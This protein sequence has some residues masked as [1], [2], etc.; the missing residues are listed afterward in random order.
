MV[1]M[2]L[3]GPLAVMRETE[4]DLLSDVAHT[5][6][7]MGDHT[8]EDRKRLMDVA[9]DLR[10]LF[11]LVVIIGEFNAGK[12]SFVNALL[13]DALL[14]TGITPT[15]EMIELVRYAEQPNRKPIMRDESLREWAHPNTGAPGVAIVDTPGTGSVFQRHE[16]VAK[17]FLHRSDL[18]IFL[19]SA[20]RA[21]AETERIYL[22]M[23]KNYG[24]KII[25]IVNQVDLLDANEQVTVR[26]FIEQQVREL[27]NLQPLIFMV[28]AKQALA[29]QA[30]GS[31]APNA[32]GMDAVRAHLRGLFEE[33]PPTKQKLLAQL[34][35]AASVVR[36]Y[37]DLIKSKADAV[38]LDTT[39]VKE[40]QQELQKQSLGL[41]AQ[42]IEARA[43]IDKVFTGMRQRGMQFID[44]NLSIRKIGSSIN[45]DKLQAEFQDVVIG[46]ALR[47][48]NEATNGYINAVIDS[49][50]V[51]WR[52]VIDRLNQLREILEQELSGLD[53]GMYAEQRENLQDAIRIAE[54]EL[55]SY[56]TGRVV[57][58]IHQEFEDNRASFNVSA[59][60]ASLG[61]ITAIVAAGPGAAPF[62]GVVFFPAALV[63]LGGGAFA[64]RYYQRVQSETKKDFSARV[65]RLMQSYHEAL[66]E[67]T[68][69]E[70]ARLSQY[71]TQVLTPIFSRLEVLAQR[72]TV[73]QSQFEGYQR[74][75]ETLRKGIEES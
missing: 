39:R 14:P 64:L 70:R 75:V 5:L 55:K 25:L 59:I 53:A 63:A 23:A 24:K 30:S 68:R 49:S 54:A 33:T 35:M 52:G 34:D 61:V 67:L 60:A 9:Q 17:E 74:R 36:R 4:I 42:L 12:S 11:F 1:T 62:L 40:V 22:E 28:S 50:R 31:P 19:L 15:T 21:F 27:L 26:R 6:G 38:T 72:Y 47:D 58:D 57:E 48:I 29:A 41:D 44:A 7:E 2:A 69:K 45:K 66:D 32:G 3:D 65:D 20:K 73:Q 13:G 51:Y 18:V 43:E 10:D 56:S 37:Y 71:G 16:K 8:Q 46:R